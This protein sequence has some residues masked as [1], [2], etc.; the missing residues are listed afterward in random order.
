MSPKAICCGNLLQVQLSPEP[1]DVNLLGVRSSCHEVGCSPRRDLREGEAAFLP[2]RDTPQVCRTTQKQGRAQPSGPPV[3]GPGQSLRRWLTAPHTRPPRSQCGVSCRARWFL[4]HR[5][6]NALSTPAG[7]NAFQED[8]RSSRDS[9][10]H[11]EASMLSLATWLGS[12]CSRVERAEQ[13]PSY[14]GSPLLAEQ[15]P[16]LMLH[17]R[18][19]VPHSACTPH[20]RCQLVKGVMRHGPTGG[21]T[22]RWLSVGPPERGRPARRHRSRLLAQ[23]HPAPQRKL[24]CKASRRGHSV[25]AVEEHQSKLVASLSHGL[26]LRPASPSEPRKLLWNQQPTGIHQKSVLDECSEYL[27]FSNQHSSV[28]S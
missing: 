14:A 16:E 18:N 25:T 11:L 9:L 12:A 27:V 5:L 4:R 3:P 6:W 13:W 24:P 21:N 10:H 20:A 23:A 15:G 28:G 19:L 1:P 2:P 8:T 17:F 22:S 26:L 7:V